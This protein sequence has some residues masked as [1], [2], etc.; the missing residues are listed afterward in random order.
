MEFH[1]E[2]QNGLLLPHT[3]IPA[4]NKEKRK[5]RTATYH[6]YACFHVFQCRLNLARPQIMDRNESR[7]NN[8]YTSLHLVQLLS[9]QSA[10]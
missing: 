4:V 2:I 9:K 10:R 8:E 1:E 5:K 3:A 6:R 7:K